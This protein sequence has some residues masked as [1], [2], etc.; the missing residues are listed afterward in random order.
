MTIAGKRFPIWLIIAYVLA[1]S[2]ILAW[3]L[4]AFSSIFMFDDPQAA[5]LTSTYVTAGAMVAYPILPIAAVIG[6]YI[7]Q[8][9]ESGR[10]AGVLAGIALLPF[11]ALF[12]LVV[13]LPIV[14]ILRALVTPY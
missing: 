10:L 3:P 12:A 13:V 4:V 9:R 14:Q 2:A 11:I 8:R 1:L 6:S 5:H 7:A